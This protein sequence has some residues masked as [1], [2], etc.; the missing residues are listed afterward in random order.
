MMSIPHILAAWVVAPWFVAAGGIAASIPIIIHILNRRRFRIVRWAAMEYLLQAMR[1][2]RRKLKFEQWVL[3]ACRCLLMILMGLALARPLGCENNSLA[4]LGGQRSGLHIL[5]IDNSYSMAYEPGGRGE[6]K[7]HLDQA[8]LMAKKVIDNL[9]TGNEAVM[10]ITASSP[11][12]RD[13][14]TDPHAVTTKPTY[15]LQQARAAIDRIEQTAAGTDL[16][17]A[18]QLALRTAQEEKSLPRKQLYIFTDGTK[19]AFEAPQSAEALKE[20]GPELAKVFGKP[21]L[22]SLGKPGQWNQ[23]VLDISPAM[24]LVTT[25]WTADFATIVKGYGN[26]PDSVVQWKLNDVP[27]GVAKSVKLD[28]ETPAQ[29]LSG[30]AIKEGGPRVFSVTLPGD[31]HLKVDNTRWRV[32]DVASEMK[33]LIVEGE[34]G[35]GALQG[36]GSFLELALSP[37]KEAESDSRSTNKKTDSYV[38][39]EPPIGE[40]ELANKVLGNYRAVFLTNVG[41]ISAPQAEQLKHYVEQGGAVIFFAGPAINADNYNQTL[42]PAGLIPG[43]LIKTVTSNDKPEHFAF[44]Y[45]GNPHPFMKEFKNQEQSGLTTALIWSYWQVELANNSPAER[46]LDYAA[47]KDPAIITHTLGRGRVVFVTTTANP[48]WNG[49]PPKPAYVTLMHELLAGSVGAGDRWMNLIVGDSL[50]IPQ[51]LGLTAAPTLIDDKKNPVAIEPV[52]SK[53][54]V[55]TYHSSKPM[56]KPGEYKL[57]TGSRT[58]PVVV[59]VPANEADIRVIS[60]EAIRKAMGDIELGVEDETFSI[61]GLLSDSGNDWSWGFMV[62]VLLLAATECFLA[63]HFG[64]HKRGSVNAPVTEG[65]KGIRG[66]LNAY[67]QPFFIS[68]VTGLTV[69]FTQYLFYGPSKAISAIVIGI[70]TFALGYPILLIKGKKMRAR[71]KTPQL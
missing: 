49:L 21:K 45:R 57:N 53:A 40:I 58:Y 66:K 29:P 61:A 36:S 28:L 63:M 59:N 71:D 9:A 12:D 27:V 47:S 32:I 20:I 23:A 55:T 22:F 5:V 7:T 54:G 30:L 16:N 26:T 64:H 6:A 41:Q 60:P 8:K 33:I 18:F 68:F 69:G 13:K 2:N 42:L 51:A 24:N 14:T 34:R 44:D 43:R 39:P 25:K 11:I 70:G 17:G 46:V 31:D 19:S 3:L 67:D 48:E 62:A 50:D 37:P 4:A 1:K 52:T 65:A 56:T 38:S 35:I 10:I 15:D